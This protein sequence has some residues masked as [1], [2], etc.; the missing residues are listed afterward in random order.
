MLH[1]RYGEDT[2]L[3]IYILS[4][5]S[6]RSTL[7]SNVAKALDIFEIFNVEEEE[8]FINFMDGANFMDGIYIQLKKIKASMN[9]QKQFVDGHP[10]SGRKVISFS[11]GMLGD[12]NV[13]VVDRRLQRAFKID[14]NTSPSNK[15]YDQVEN[16]VRIIARA[17][18]REPRQVSAAIRCSI[19]RKYFK[20][21]KDYGVALLQQEHKRANR[22]IQ[23]EYIASISTL[24]SE[25][26]FV[27]AE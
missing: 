21:Q 23:K 20:D 8:E 11:N 14:R 4:A 17:I 27:E 25:E 12:K 26:S 13:V 22:K 7:E 1:K 24:F 16:L 6:I 2:E 9:D 18:G 3:M 5:T 15:E 10:L 19:R